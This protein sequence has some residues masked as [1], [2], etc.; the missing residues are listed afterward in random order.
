MVGI[1]TLNTVVQ[2]A[3]LLGQKVPALIDAIRPLL[4]KEDQ[5][6]LQALLDA[7]DQRT[8]MA[9]ERAEKA[10]KEGQSRR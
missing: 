8:D 3:N 4:S 6:K 9:D 10:L 2:L 7:S 1:D 5:T